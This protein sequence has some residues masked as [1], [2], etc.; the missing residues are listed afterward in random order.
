MNKNTQLRDIIKNNGNN[1][2]QNEDKFKHKTIFI[3]LTKTIL[4]LRKVIFTMRN[5]FEK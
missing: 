2:L 5:Q 3:Y 4:K 1:I